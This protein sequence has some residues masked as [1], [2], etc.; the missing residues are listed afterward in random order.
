MEYECG[1]GE[2]DRGVIPP[3]LR[4]ASET[5]AM[6]YIRISPRTL[7]CCLFC[8]RLTDRSTLSISLSLSL[9]LT[10]SPVHLAGPSVVI[11]T[12]TR[13]CRRIEY[14]WTARRMYHSL[15]TRTAGQRERHDTPRRERGGGFGFSFVKIQKCLL[16]APCVC[17]RSGC[18]RRW[19]GMVQRGIAFLP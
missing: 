6:L 18:H 2:R 10:F 14:E 11:R 4:V 13:R 15:T 1:Q 17:S 12:L 8:K 3:A 9:S 7:G 5:S 16:H 19:A